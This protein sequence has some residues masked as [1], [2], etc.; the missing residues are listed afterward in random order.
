MFDAIFILSKLTEEEIYQTKY[1]V[2][3]FTEI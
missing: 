3:A 2:Y 1:L